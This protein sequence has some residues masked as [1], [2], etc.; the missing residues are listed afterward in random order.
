LDPDYGQCSERFS[1]LGQA[2][3]FL[4]IV[5]YEDGFIWRY[6]Y[7]DSGVLRAH[8]EMYGGGVVYLP[9]LTKAYAAPGR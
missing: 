7:H 3:I 8:I 5:D 9:V 2:W 1:L 6:F 4:S